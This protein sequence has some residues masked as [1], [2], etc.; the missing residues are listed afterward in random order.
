[1]HVALFSGL[2][3]HIVAFLRERGR[4][5]VNIEIRTDQVD[6]P[7]VKGFTEVA[8]ELLDNDPRIANATGFDTVEKKVVTG[9][10]TTT[11]KMPTELDFSPQVS[12]LS[13]V[14]MP[15]SDGLVLAADVLANSL[16]YL[17]KS[18]GADALYGPLNCMDAIA[19][20]PLAEHLDAFFDWGGGLYW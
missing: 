1:M 4:Q 14:T 5:G 20:H 9:S 10:V 12:K 3:S 6:A 18:R 7:L 11:V 17:F 2:Y 13:I 8:K 16:N 19:G 15:D